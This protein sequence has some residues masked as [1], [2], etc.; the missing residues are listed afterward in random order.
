[1]PLTTKEVGVSSFTEEISSLD[2]RSTYVEN[3]AYANV[4]E[5]N[6]TTPYTLNNKSSIINV[7]AGYSDGALASLR[8]SSGANLNVSFNNQNGWSWNGSV[9]SASPASGQ[10]PFNDD[11]FLRQKTYLITFKVLSYTSGSLGYRFGGGN[12]ENGYFNNDLIEG[13][14]ISF[15]VKSDAIVN[16]F[17]FTTND[18]NGSLSEISFTELDT[19]D[20]DFTRASVATRVN[21]Q[22]LI[23][24]V[25]I[26]I[27]RIDYTDGTGSWLFEPQS[28]NI[29]TDSEALTYFNSISNATTSSVSITN[30]KGES[31]AIKYIPNSGTGGNRSI[32]RSVSGLSELHT[33]S[34]F[35]KKDELRYLFLRMR[36]SPSDMAVFDLQDG[37]VSDTKQTTQLVANSPKI[38]NYG[39]GWYR[40]SAT[41]DPSGSDTV[42]TL[43]FS[44]SA[45]N[46]GS[47]TSSFNGDG[48]SGLF[49]WGA[50]IEA[51]S[52]ATS[53]IITSGATVTRSADVANNSGNADLFNDSEGVL[54]AEIAALADDG[55]L[56]RLSISDGTNNNRVFIGY[57]SSNRFQFVVADGGSVVVNKLVTVSDIALQ[58]KVAFK[59]KL[60]DCAIWINGY[61]VDTD[62]VATM[63]SGL[64]TL[65]FDQGNGGNDLYGKAKCVAVFK[66]ALTDEELA[67]I[68]STTQQEVF[69]AMRDRMN[70]KNYDYYE[71]DDYTT[72]LKKLF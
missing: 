46:T 66:E 63:P 60:N 17:Q 52:Y 42:G 47:Q 4:L 61:E 37:V 2:R 71:F 70:M 67:Q 30:P 44:F 41:F 64:D 26:D 38:E 21:E 6:F 50:Q 11:R 24:Q 49:L 3:R 29:V 14:I 10:A 51:E 1:M 28:T 65:N 45:D 16:N 68:T 57:S 23:E 27:P 69:Y 39:N 25:A 9:L 15:Q 35:A 40:C 48:V 19:A 8:P 34:V 32:G 33:F 72:R 54:Y 59:Y 5:N 43:F 62:T 58:N 55:T 36:N 22:G 7:P 56:R 53:Y 13:N 18:F 20:F 31:A 12:V